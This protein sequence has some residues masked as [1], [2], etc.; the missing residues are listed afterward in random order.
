MLEELFRFVLH[1]RVQISC[2][3]RPPSE[4]ARG[5]CSLLL[6]E[7]GF[8]SDIGGGMNILQAFNKLALR[9][10]ISEEGERALRDLFSSMGKG[11]LEDEIR[12]IDSALSVLSPLVEKERSGALRDSRL[13]STL[14][15]SFALGVIILLM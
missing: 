7:S 14:S 2:F 11:Y 9:E 12:L 5:F 1:I 10:N 4:L 3:L 13:I 6:E 8:L 15:A